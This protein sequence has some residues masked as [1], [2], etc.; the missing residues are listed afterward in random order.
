[1]AKGAAKEQSMGD[2]HSAVARVFNRVL[3]TYEKRLAAA[4]SIDITEVGEE[5]LGLLM[6]DNI[7]PNPAMLAA[8]TKFLKDNEIS[9]DI[10]EI[11][12]LSATEERLK[13]RKDKRGKLS[14][15]TNLVL[16][17]ANVG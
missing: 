13:A 8:V 15:L 7:M 5:V 11:E 6:D 16:V 14:N 1:M 2:L 9:F 10:E 17:D 12:K 4:E 3:E